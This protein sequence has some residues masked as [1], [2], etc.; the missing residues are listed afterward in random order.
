[1]EV[2]TF[3][4]KIT[5]VLCCYQTEMSGEVEITITA[6]IFS[7]FFFSFFLLFILFHSWVK[8]GEII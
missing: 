2:E 8:C 5:F 6:G 7:L 4:K 1:M 3:Q